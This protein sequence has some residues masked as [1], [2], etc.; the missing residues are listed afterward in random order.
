MTRPIPA[1][2][3]S[4]GVRRTSSSI[5]WRWRRA[6]TTRAPYSMKEPSST[7]SSTFSRAVRC[8][9]RRRRSTA[10]GRRS[11][12]VSAW[13]SSTSARSG[14]IASRSSA[15]SLPSAGGATSASS[16]TTSGLP[17]ATVSPS[18]TA[19]RRTRP[20]RSAAIT[21]CIFIASMT[22]SSRP[23]CIGSPSPT[24]I[25]I[26]VPC[27][28]ARIAPGSGTPGAAAGARPAPARSGPFSLPCAST[29]SGSAVSTLVPANT[30]GRR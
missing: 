8:P 9:V 15:S 18:C 28:G 7:R 23:T 10:S 11:S 17:S 16:S 24:N 2:S 5:E 21:C 20:L 19:R 29:A 22:S 1:T 4:A 3:P 27:I 13:R 6:A 26:T 30:A 14:R 25:S 12:R